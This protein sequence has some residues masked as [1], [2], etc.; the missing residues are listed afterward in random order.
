[1]FELDLSLLEKKLKENNGII[2][3]DNYINTAVLIPIVIVDDEFCLLYEKRSNKIRQGG[4]V[5]FPGG[6]FDPDADNDLQQTAIRE[7]T[8]ELGI[9]EDKIKLLGK[10]G[11][12]V[13]PMGMIIEVFVAQLNVEDPYS[14]PYDKT[15]VEEIFVVPLASLITTKP[16]TYFVDIFVHNRKVD[17]KGNESESLPVTKYGLPEKYSNKWGEA[18]HC[19]LVYPNYKNVIWG[20]TAKITHEFTRL[21]KGE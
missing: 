19:V 6:E 4:E 16:E 12:L 17:E 3:R 1:M 8:E 21:L 20:L 15:E 10:F 11:S 9:T 5:S 14:L 2:G 18:K 13:A 7:T